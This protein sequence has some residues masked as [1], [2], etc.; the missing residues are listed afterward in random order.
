VLD[1]QVC[2]VVYSPLRHKPFQYQHQL[3]LGHLQSF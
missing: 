1:K 2:S 3:R